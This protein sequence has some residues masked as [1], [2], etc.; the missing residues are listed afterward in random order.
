LWLRCATDI[1]RKNPFENSIVSA[2]S[3]DGVLLR[4]LERRYQLFCMPC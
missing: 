4:A 1:P 2:V 3:S